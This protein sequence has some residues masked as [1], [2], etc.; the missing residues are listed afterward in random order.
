MRNSSSDS[1]V[2][3]AGLQFEMSGGPWPTRDEDR[4]NPPSEPP[5]KNGI[6]PA[7]PALGTARAWSITL[8]EIPFVFPRGRGGGC[9]RSGAARRG[10][11]RKR[12]SPGRA[13]RR[14]GPRP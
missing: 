6:A 10:R 4:V 7:K 8:H 13:R 14:D 11:R 5:P 12:S 3:G 9:D 1:I 2:L